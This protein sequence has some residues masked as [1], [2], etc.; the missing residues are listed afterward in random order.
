MSGRGA[1]RR[2]HWLVLS[3]D[4]SGCEYDLW[5]SSLGGACGYGKRIGY[6]LGWMMGTLLSPERT[7]VAGSLVG[8]GACGP[9]V[10]L[11]DGLLFRC[12]A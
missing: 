2:R 5:V 8:V 6:G 10:G 12:Q 9:L 11:V 4:G 1:R 3:G 7:T